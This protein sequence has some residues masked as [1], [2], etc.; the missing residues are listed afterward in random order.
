[1]SL[2]RLP[3][4]LITL[5]LLIATA[6]CAGR[7]AKLYGTVLQ[8]I[9]PAPP[10]A[11]LDQNGVRFSLPSERGH[12]VALYFGFTHCKDICPQTLAKLGA[13]RAKSGLGSRV[14]IVFA[15]VDPV[16]D[17]PAALRRFFR[18]VGT[19]AIGLTGSLAQMKT[20]WSAYGV[21]VQATRG[22][23]GHSDFVYFIGPR[24]NLRVV[25]GDM[26]IAQI[27]ADMRGLA[28]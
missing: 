18:R 15:S 3:L 28:R 4:R 9:R 16:R 8:P 6:A 20:I 26:T 13:A 17:T 1:M 19:S 23:V 22:D 27:T 24:G 11:A 10:L 21:D 7:P 5:A 12:V 2:R 25:G 14:A